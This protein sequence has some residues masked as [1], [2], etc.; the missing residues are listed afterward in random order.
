MSK[1]GSRLRDRARQVRER[2]TRER[3][4]WNPSPESAHYRLYRKWDEI[5]GKAPAKENF[6]HYW[7]VVLLWAPFALFRQGV[8][9]AYQHKSVVIGT[10]VLL[11]VLLVAGAAWL[12]TT[13]T[14]MVAGI[15]LIILAAIYLLFG[16]VTSVQ[17]GKEILNENDEPLWEWLDE[18]DY[19][20]KCLF[21]LAFSPV[22]IALFVLALLVV[23]II[24]FVVWVFDEKE[25]GSKLCMFFFELHPPKV[26]W[27]RPWMA[28]P[29]ALFV[30]APFFHWAF[31]GTMIVLAAGFLAACLLLLFWGVDVY[32]RHLEVR[33]DE[34]ARQQLE[35]RKTQVTSLLRDVH[36][37]IHP[38]KQGN[39][40]HFQR[41]L[42]RYMRH[43]FGC[44]EYLWYADP[45]THYNRH[46]IYS[47]YSIPIGLDATKYG[48]QKRRRPLRATGD[49]F[50]LI[51][52][53]IVARKWQICPIVEVSPPH[54]ESRN[55]SGAGTGWGTG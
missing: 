4:N 35:L 11:A 21:A 8:K 14:G 28:F 32:K 22:G 37:R 41:W 6:C 45:Q 30:M 42:E 18:Q 36:S 34:L 19:G 26:S 47:G 1:L 7:R 25:L 44:W 10:L 54:G 53:V 52:A 20:I 39:E 51:W 27:L 40:E 46:R 3:R 31:V 29:L 12:T 5:T 48:S 23:S 50:A 43:A 55:P 49:F 33:K 2:G 16:A 9:D 15:S 13:F 24:G 38:K 17:F